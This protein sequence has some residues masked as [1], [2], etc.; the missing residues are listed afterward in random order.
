LERDG[1]DLIALNA[2]LYAADKTDR[3]ASLRV[4]LREKHANKLIMTYATIKAVAVA[5]NPI[6]VAD[7]LGGV[8]V[9]ATMVMMLA[10]VYGLEMS[11]EKA[12]ELSKAILKSAGWIGI[13]EV[14]GAAIKFFTLT[15]ATPF[16]ILPQGAA[17]GY[18][19]YIVGHASKYYFEHGASWGSSGPKN[20]VKEILASTDKQ[21]IISSLKE[22]IQSK[23][24]LNRHA[25][26]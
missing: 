6:A 12:K 4:A 10:K 9:D 16:T 7:V 25:K 14:V 26:V 20:V 1:L 22:E 8:A 17:A 18:S 24:S 23:L 21:S 13:G 2:A 3:I 5:A 15:A 19:S 11:L